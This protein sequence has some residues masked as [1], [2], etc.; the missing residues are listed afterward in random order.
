MFI[1]AHSKAE[2]PMAMYREAC[3]DMDNPHEDVQGDA[4]REETRKLRRRA[5]GSPW[6]LGPGGLVMLVSYNIFLGFEMSG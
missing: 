3:V 1:L 5:L 2:S 6:G 4:L